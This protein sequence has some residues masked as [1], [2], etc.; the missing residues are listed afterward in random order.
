MTPIFTSS[1]LKA[2]MPLLHENAGS[3]TKYL[4]RISNSKDATMDCKDTFRRLIIEILGNLGCG[5]EADVLN[6]KE[7]LFYQQ[8]NNYLLQLN[9][10]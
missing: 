4:L 8:V 6:G 1:K 9:F 3:L 5:F 2:I 10:E 7:N